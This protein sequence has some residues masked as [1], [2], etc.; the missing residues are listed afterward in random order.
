MSNGRV[1]AAASRGKQQIVRKRKP[2]SCIRCYSIKRKCDH[3]KPSCSRCIKKGLPCEYFTEEHVLERCLERQK[4][5]RVSN[6]GSTGS[7]T[8]P[9]GDDVSVND[10][11]MPDT[12]LNPIPRETESRNFK[13]IVNSTGEYSKYLSLSLFPFSDPSQNVSYIVDR[14]PRDADHYVVYD[15]SYVPS[16]LSGKEEI[17]KLIPNKMHCDVLVSY[18]FANISPFIPI[19]DVEEFELKYNELWKNVQAYDDLNMLMILFAVI[20]AS[21]VSIQVSK[22]YFTG[23][24][25]SDDEVINYEELKY[26]CFQCV[27]NIKH[28]TNANISPSMSGITALTIMYYV[29]SL[30]CYGVSGEVSALLRYCQIAG[31]HRSLSQNT[32]SSS[33]RAFLY[34]YVVHL[35]S[36]V[37]YYNG[38]T[39][40]VNKD[41]FETVRNFPKHETKIETL[42]SLAKLYN[43]LVW[44]D[45]LNQLNKI[46]S[47]TEEDFQRLNREYLT[48]MEKVNSLN[49]EI[50]TM[51]Q[52]APQDYLKLLVAEGRLGIRKSALL[53]H[54]LR[55]SV[56]GSNINK[57]R[58]G[59]SLNQDLVI[60]ALLLINESLAK[61]YLGVKHN[62]NLLWF[63]RNSYPFQA[64]SIVL[65]HIQKNPTKGINFSHLQRDVEYTTHPE[66]NY[67]SFDIRSDLILKTTEALRSIKPLWP[68]V[69]QRR[70]ERICE[71]KNY[72]FAQNPIQY[73][74]SNQDNDNNK[75]N[76]NQAQNEGQNQNQNQGNSPTGS[77]SFDELLSNLFDGDSELQSLFFQTF[78]N[79]H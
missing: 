60:Q 61:I 36:L 38:L 69:F 2:K 19:I 5:G 46:E 35:D 71:L 26:S 28:M 76:N 45:L 39:S 57:V 22:I 59:T 40:Y 34:S 20:F 24:H 25:Y 73:S 77:L 55:L 79:S 11:N 78:P 3:Q 64:M 14:M 13:L 44:I 4:K 70:F 62:P 30:N 47:S 42:F 72:V 41:L 63:V 66:I 31:L 32:N 53:V 54:F 27:E 67:D 52:D 17:K 56:S 43:G 23:K 15:F 50:L 9:S 49:A 21:C 68:T 37:A 1:S 65:T 48:S 29:G 12:E 10:E 7:L 51:F 16:R 6:A 8:T 33:V 75:T 58:E 74:N 18:Y